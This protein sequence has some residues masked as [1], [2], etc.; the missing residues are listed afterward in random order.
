MTTH[1]GQSAF[2]A[3]VVEPESATG[4][5][6]CV[7]YGRELLLDFQ[8][9]EPC[10]L[11]GG[12]IRF[13]APEPVTRLFL[14]YWQGTPC[15]AVEL[16]RES[17]LEAPQLTQG[18][19]YHLLGRVDD[20][21]FALAGN[22]QQLLAWARDNRFCGRCGETMDYHTSERARTCAPCEMSIYPSIAPC[23]ITL[24]SRGEEL[25]L[26]RNANFPG[27]M[28]ST[29]AGFIEVGE[30]VEDC[31][32]REVKEEVGV[33]VGEMRYFG[34]QPWP[35]PN[36]LML[37]FFAEYSGGDIVC[38]DE[39]IAEAHWFRPDDLPTIPPRHSIAG[40]LIRHHVAL[41]EGRP[42]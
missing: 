26:A 15:Y 24:V 33:D 3:S 39:E 23:I 1:M 17:P 10:L 8:S 13:L 12:A 18:S 36:Q 40:Q 11:D 29:L 34:S 25:L 42:V 28:F 4:A 2:E 16:D 19:L 38:E 30:S 21:L 7:F 41:H 14:G 9:R 37:G 32:R 20:A 22:A 27:E 35:F 31:L 5:R 6:Y